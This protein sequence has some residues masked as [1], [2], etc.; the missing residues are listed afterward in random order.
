[1]SGSTTTAE[2]LVATTMSN[3]KETMKTLIT[4]TTTEATKAASAS[5]TTTSTISPSSSSSSSSLPSVTSPA[6]QHH[7][8]DGEKILNVSD[9]ST[10]MQ[11]FGV[12]D[13]CVFVLMLIVCAGIGFYFGFIEKKTKKTKNVEHRRGS[14]ALDYLVGGRKM[15]VFPVSLSLV[16][17]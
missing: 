14:E 12:M 8:S 6:H 17:R 1:M 2:K 13:Y 15:K 11:H 10:S 9:L 5:T 7:G 4:T 3:I 16:A